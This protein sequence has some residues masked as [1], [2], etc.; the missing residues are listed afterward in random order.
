[1]HLTNFTEW[2]VLV[3]KYRDMVCQYRQGHRDGE[4]QLEGLEREKFLIIYFTPTG[5]LATAVQTEPLPSYCPLL[6]QRLLPWSSLLTT[7]SPRTSTDGIVM[8]CSVAQ[9]PSHF[10]EFMCIPYSPFSGYP[11]VALEVPFESLKVTRE[12]GRV[13]YTSFIPMDTVLLLSHGQ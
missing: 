2:D 12:G 5:Q 4:L 11:F 7:V 3:Y 13:K 9:N 8:E 1:M 6:S 10:S